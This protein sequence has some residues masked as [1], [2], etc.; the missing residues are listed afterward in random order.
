MKF[1]LDLVISIICLSYSFPTIE[2]KIRK[3]YP[4]T[5]ETNYLVTYDKLKRHFFFFRKILIIKAPKFQVSQREERKKDCERRKG[6]FSGKC[7]RAKKI[8]SASMNR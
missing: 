6:N 8:C 3:N 5:I 7:G 4:L 1:G 2:K